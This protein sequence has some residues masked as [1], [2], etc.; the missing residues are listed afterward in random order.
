MRQRIAHRHIDRSYL[1]GKRVQQREQQLLVRKQH[2]RGE[3]IHG[4]GGLRYLL[5]NPAN[6]L[7][8]TGCGRNGDSRN[9]RNTLTK[10]SVL[11]QRVPRRIAADIVLH[12]KRGLVGPV[13]YGLSVIIPVEIPLPGLEQGVEQLP[14]ASVGCIESH[15]DDVAV[16]LQDLQ[17]FRISVLETLGHRAVDHAL[18]CLAPGKQGGAERGVYVIH[19]AP[20]TYEVTLIGFV[21]AL[22]EHAPEKLYRLTLIVGQIVITAVYLL[23]IRDIGEKPPGIH[24][25]LVDI[26][27]VV[28]YHLST[29]DEIIQA[30]RESLHPLHEHRIQ[31]VQ[32]SDLIQGAQAGQSSEQVIDIGQ[33]GGEYGPGDRLP[34]I[35]AEKERRPPVGEYESTAPQ[36]PVRLG[37]EPLGHTPEKLLSHL[38][39]SLMASA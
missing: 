30:L 25:I 36:I 2:R 22:Y 4:T 34:E 15:E 3:K 7:G 16:A 39:L 5:Q 17:Q 35:S 26:I 10:T 37:K 11:R 29:V 8:L 23:D 20:H 38:S 31:A 28:E 18:V 33:A 1:L 12:E 21:P 32:K 24:Q 6:I 13:L 14:L 9:L 19:P 27:E